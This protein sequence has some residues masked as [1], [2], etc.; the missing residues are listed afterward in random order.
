MYNINEDVDGSSPGIGL[1][2]S[3][4]V[5]YTNAN[6]LGMGPIIAPQ[7]S[8]IPGDTSG[9]T[10]GSG[11]VANYLGGTTYDKMYNTNSTK[12]RKKSNSST[13][14]NRFSD[15]MKLKK[16]KKEKVMKFKDYDKKFDINKVTR[17]N[18]F[19]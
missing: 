12:S 3:T 18:D 17:L 16:T 5:A 8:A 7:P 13:S 14:L 15:N 2:S 9:S 4:G 6:A 11:D 19:K 1:A 10:I